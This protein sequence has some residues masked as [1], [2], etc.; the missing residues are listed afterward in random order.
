M[1]LK[2]MDRYAK[3]VHQN[4]EIDL[5]NRSLV[6]QPLE[7]KAFEEFGNVI[8]ASI[9]KALL[10]NDGNTSFINQAHIDYS[11]IIACGRSI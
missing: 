10:I 11:A 5:L 1:L 6:P 8:D 4:L 2:P 3:V 9:Q 7:E